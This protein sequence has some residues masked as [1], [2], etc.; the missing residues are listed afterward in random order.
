MVAAIVATA[1]SP[2]A[3]APAGAQLLDSFITAGK[4]QARWIDVPSPPPGATDTKSIELT[5]HARSAIDFNDAAWVTLRGFDS[6]R[7]PRL[8]ASPT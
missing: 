6:D 7:R 2:V 5:V 3:A 4:A 1:F 8:P